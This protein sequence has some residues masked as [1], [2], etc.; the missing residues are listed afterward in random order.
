VVIDKKEAQKAFTLLKEM[1]SNPNKYYSE[2]GYEKDLKPSTIQLVWNDT[3]AKVAENKAYD[4][5]N[6]NYYGHIDPEG[7]GINH[8]IAKSGYKLNSLWT[9]NKADNYFESLT[10]NLPNGEAAI[11]FLV[12]DSLTPSLGHRKHLLGLDKW[13]STLRD[14]GIGFARRESGST[15]RTYVCV[16]IAKHDW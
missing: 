14:V 10:A 4:M 7:F 8:F 3:L 6:R 11:K 1:R 2:L 16:I 13:N 5:A 12:K 15:Y 9:A